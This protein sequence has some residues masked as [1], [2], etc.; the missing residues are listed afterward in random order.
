[1][2]YWAHTEVVSAAPPTPGRLSTI[3][4]PPPMSPNSDAL[5]DYN[6][7]TIIGNKTTILLLINI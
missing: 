4:W 5:S 1:M 2:Y 7:K 6:G 3:S